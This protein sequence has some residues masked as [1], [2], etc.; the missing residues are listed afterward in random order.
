MVQCVQQCPRRP[1]YPR[2]G[3][4]QRE[5]CGTRGRPQCH[6]QEIGVKSGGAT[7]LCS[8]LLVMRMRTYIPLLTMALCMAPAQLRPAAFDLS[9]IHISEPTRLGMISY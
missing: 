9:L 8:V 3:R 1:D 7:Q 5:G 2:C 6:R 4:N